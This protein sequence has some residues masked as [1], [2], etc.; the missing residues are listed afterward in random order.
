M[1]LRAQDFR[2]ALDDVGAGNAGLDILS[3]LPVD[4][5]KI[6]GELVKNAVIDQRSRSV[7]AGIVAITHENNTYVIAEGIE[8]TDILALVQSPSYKEIRARGIHGG[9][10]YFLGRPQ[11]AVPRSTTFPSTPAPGPTGDP[12]CL[13]EDLSGLHIC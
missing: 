4:F 2:V 13:Q 10:G 3:R 5:L 8:D 11:S 6:D 1:R 9:Q 7:L 12:T